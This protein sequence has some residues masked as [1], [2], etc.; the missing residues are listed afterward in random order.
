MIENIARDTEIYEAIKNSDK[1]K[2]FENNVKLKD[3]KT[4]G[5]GKYDKKIIEFL[6]NKY[7]LSEVRVKNIYENMEIETIYKERAKN[8][9]IIYNLEPKVRNA[10]LR[11]GFENIEDVLDP[12]RVQ[13]RRKV[14]N[15][16]NGFG[17]RALLEL[18]KFCKENNCNC[19]EF[20]KTFC[21]VKSGY[22]YEDFEK[23]LQNIDNVNLCTG[24][25]F[26]TI[27][28]EVKNINND[29]L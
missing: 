19:I 12:T 10:L 29:K 4:K 14:K 11:N 27:K 28:D 1:M 23:I 16:F 20:N 22:D 9:N 7:N 15:I 18:N 3:R 26:T 8:G 2:E 24:V 21:S 5:R 17:F 25:N 13:K 6:C